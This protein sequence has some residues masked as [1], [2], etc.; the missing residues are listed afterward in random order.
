MRQNPYNRVK[1]PLNANMNVVPY[2]DVMLVLLVIFMVAT[3]MMK[4]GVDVDLPSEQT[5]SLE[6]GLQLLVIVTL[7]D[8][9]KIF[10][11]YDQNT[12]IAVNNDE[13]INTLLKLQNNSL[14]NNGLQVMINADQKNDYGSIMALMANIQQAGITKIGLL[15]GSP[16]D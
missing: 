7:S 15:T 13:L 9:G 12:D 2:I 3:P 14:D 10:M 1:K 4:T 11:S 16:T 8:T 6:T 5:Q